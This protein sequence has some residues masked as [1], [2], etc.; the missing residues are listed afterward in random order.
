MNAI[1]R[2]GRRFFVVPIARVLIGMHIHPNV[3]TLLSL[4]FAVG[5]FFFYWRGCFPI[6]ALFLLLCGLLDTFDGEIARR[7]NTMTKFGGFLDST[8]DR[9]NEFIVHLGLFSYYYTHA[10][11][12][13]IWIVLAM[14]GSM[15]VS[16]TRARGEGLG[17]SP[18]VGI[19]ERFLRI[20]ILII[21][22]CAG[23]RYM[24]WAFVIL[25]IGTVQTMIHRI[26]YTW[27]HSAS[28]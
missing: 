20:L 13:L 14:F 18:Q 4:V 1:K 9:I 7:T 26:V 11:Y 5:A 2:I 21:G 10:R 22:S 28:E 16:Y 6:G 15:M 8:V 12:V 27:K 24:V 19:F 23:P 25:A 17:I 3:I